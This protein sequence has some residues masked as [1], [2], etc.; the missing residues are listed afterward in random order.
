MS[1][2]ATPPPA[3]A[4]NFSAALSDFVRVVQF[5]DRDRACCYDLSVT[6]CYA[7]ERVVQAGALTVNELSAALYLDKSTAS[8]A[9]NSLVSKGMLERRGH[10]DDGR[11][12]RLV[13]TTLGTSTC[14]RIEEDLADE[15]SALL[16][17]FE[18]AVQAASAEVLRRLADAFSRRVDVSNGRCCTVPAPSEGVTT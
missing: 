13:P 9:A 11:I 10:P 1:T 12:V 18:P 3:L 7:L 5:R 17:D 6:Q 14:R 16:A 15:Y 4:Q 2:I 8:R